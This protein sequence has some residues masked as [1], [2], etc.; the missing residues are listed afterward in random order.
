MSKEFDWSGLSR[1][2][3]CRGSSS[4]LAAVVALLFEVQATLNCAAIS[5]PHQDAGENQEQHARVHCQNLILTHK[6]RS[7]FPAPS[8]EGQRLPCGLALHCLPY[9]HLRS[10]AVISDAR[11]LA[12]DRRNC[13]LWTNMM[14]RDPEAIDLG[15][16]YRTVGFLGTP[17][18]RVVAQH[19]WPLTN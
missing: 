6:L 14:L 17:M 4:F 12:N 16:H 2:Q 13:K 7:T 1:H 15:S 11:C 3:R 19:R 8:H 9:S 18:W 5:I 10:G